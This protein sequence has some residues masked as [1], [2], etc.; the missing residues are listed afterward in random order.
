MPAFPKS[1]IQRVSLGPWAPRS[2]GSMRR[3]QMMCLERFSRLPACFQASVWTLTSRRR[4]RKPSKGNTMKP[5]TR[6]PHQPERNP[7]K[8]KPSLF[9][10]C[11]TQVILFGLAGNAKRL[12]AN[13]NI[14]QEEVIPSKMT[15]VGFSLASTP[16][17]NC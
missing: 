9:V 3:R 10:V 12:W 4:A 16:L 15:F 14:L 11:G 5:N 8:L 6:N 13:Y 1:S 7:A 2:A 17:P